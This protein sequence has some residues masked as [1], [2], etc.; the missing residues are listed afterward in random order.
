[1]NAAGGYV[2][3]YFADR[4]SSLFL[5]WILHLFLICP[6][7]LIFCLY[8]GYCACKFQK[9]LSQILTLPQN[10]L[11]FA[12]FPKGRRT[13]QANRSFTDRKKQTRRDCA[14]SVA[15]SSEMSIQNVGIRGS[16]GEP[17]QDKWALHII[18]YICCEH[19]V[20]WNLKSA[21]PFSLFLSKCFHCASACYALWSFWNTWSL[22]PRMSDDSLSEF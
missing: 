12:R 4:Y 6:H 10:C 3:M 2:A 11:T 8:L 1:M 14:E 19:T 22:F 9:K 13:R 16:V 7:I 20:V 15:Q 17:G 21:A 5:L 18:L